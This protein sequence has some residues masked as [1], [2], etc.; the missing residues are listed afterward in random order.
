MHLQDE[1]LP[2]EILQRAQDTEYVDS[3]DDVFR[4]AGSKI[5]KASPRS[6]N[7]QAFVER[8]IQRR[9]H[10]VLNAFCMVNEQYL[11]QI[12]RI[13]GAGTISGAATPAGIICHLYVTMMSR[14]SWISRKSRSSATANSAAI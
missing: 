1:G 10:E 12:L 9:K 7:L 13:G 11:D 8:V 6:P 2:C 4:S 5:K 3:F 14:R